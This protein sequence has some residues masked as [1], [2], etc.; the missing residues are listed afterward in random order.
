[1]TKKPNTVKRN[2]IFLIVVICSRY[3]SLVDSLFVN[4]TFCIS[5]TNLVFAPMAM[6]TLKLVVFKLQHKKLWVF[7]KKDSFE[8]VP[9][10]LDMC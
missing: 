3:K 10:E 9:I 6:I 8:N 7:E 5:K 2:L 1:M 4:M